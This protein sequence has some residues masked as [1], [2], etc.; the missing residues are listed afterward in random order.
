MDFD[1]SD[2]FR[3]S[4]GYHELAIMGGSRYR[5]TVSIV[6]S[7]FLGRSDLLTSWSW[8][9][10]TVSPS[11]AGLDAVSSRWLGCVGVECMFVAGFGL[12]ARAEA[13]GSEDGCLVVSFSQLL[14]SFGSVPF[15]VLSPSC[16]TSTIAVGAACASRFSSVGRVFC[17]G[18]LVISAAWA[19]GFSRYCRWA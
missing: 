3:S 15:R 7:I 10:N 5:L 19:L 9:W 17:W 13:L 6:L 2:P 8:I 12:W 18:R 1:R 14:Y 11:A 4:V 16:P